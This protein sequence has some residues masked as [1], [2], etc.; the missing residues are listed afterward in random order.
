MLVP[1]IGLEMGEKLKK[2]SHQMS[3]G[4]LR[5]WGSQNFHF[6][7]FDGGGIS[8]DVFASYRLTRLQ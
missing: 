8:R 1:E 3:F 5:L 6:T 2:I 4:I 7:H